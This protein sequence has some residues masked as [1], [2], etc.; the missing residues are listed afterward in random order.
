MFFLV[1]VALWADRVGKN[2]FS[3]SVSAL[4][5]CE[6]SRNVDLLFQ[7]PAKAFFESAQGVCFMYIV[8]YETILSNATN[9]KTTFNLTAFTRFQTILVNP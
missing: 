3:L 5:K 4:L 9:A 7:V 2:I 6:N 8:Q 1:K